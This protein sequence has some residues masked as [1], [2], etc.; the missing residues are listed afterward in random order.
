MSKQ[1]WPDEKE[2]IER[3]E[4]EYIRQKYRLNSANRVPYNICKVRSVFCGS[5]AFFWQ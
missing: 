1:D 3:I 5:Y 4:P 2:I